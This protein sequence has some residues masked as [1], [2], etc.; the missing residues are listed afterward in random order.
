MENIAN[1]PNGAS[2]VIRIVKIIAGMNAPN[3]QAI[4]LSEND[5]T[6]AR[7]R[8]SGIP[9]I[10]C[11]APPITMV[12]PMKNRPNILLAAGPVPA[13]GGEGTIRS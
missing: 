8:F 6:N 12:T 3:M 2:G 4:S 1:A 11:K 9:R 7:M 13:D 10:S 5:S